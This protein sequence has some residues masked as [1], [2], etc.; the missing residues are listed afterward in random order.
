MG[1]KIFADPDR[2]EEDASEARLTMAISQ[3][4][5]EK[6]INAMQ[7]GD[8]GVFSSEELNKTIE[9]AEKIYDKVFPEIDKKTKTL[10]GK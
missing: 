4:K 6:I 3:P 5:K 10:M 7:K 2:E 1:D 9:Q 8:M